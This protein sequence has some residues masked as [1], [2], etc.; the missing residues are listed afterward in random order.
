MQWLFLVRTIYL[1]SNKHT[2]YTRL[3]A[4]YGMQSRIMNIDEINGWLDITGTIWV[5][6][7]GFLQMKTGF[8]ACNLLKF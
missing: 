2:R 8:H 1:F 4:I 6:D 7:A 3:T 5:E